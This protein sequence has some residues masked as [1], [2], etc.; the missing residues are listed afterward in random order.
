[1]H[2]T[3]LTPNVT[4]G[5]PSLKTIGEFESFE[6]KPL[7]LLWDPAINAALSFTIK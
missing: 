7:I 4:L 2:P 1:M 5:K 6:H 3:M